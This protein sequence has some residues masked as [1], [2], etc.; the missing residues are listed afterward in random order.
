MTRTSYP[1]DLTD[2]RWDNIE[3]LFPQPK[4]GGRPRN[5]DNRELVNGVSSLALPHKS[6]GG[7]LGNVGVAHITQCD[8]SVYAVSRKST[9]VVE[10]GAPPLSGSIHT[11]SQGFF[12]ASNMLAGMAGL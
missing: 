9:C 1:S 8:R 3:H 5:Y 11:V 7:G 4:R 12:Q 10:R 2:L 6:N